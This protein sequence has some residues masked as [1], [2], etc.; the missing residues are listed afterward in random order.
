MKSIL[1]IGGI[2]FIILLILLTVRT[3]EEINIQKNG[4]KKDVTIFSIPVSCGESSKLSKPYF[5][6]YI[7]DKKYIK[8]LERHC[9]LKPGDK[10]SL[11]TNQDYSIFIFKDENLELELLSCFCLLIFGIICFFKSCKVSKTL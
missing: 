3:F 6:F 8:N 10:I 4:V 1:K 9:D 5:E 2:L 11:M 7:N